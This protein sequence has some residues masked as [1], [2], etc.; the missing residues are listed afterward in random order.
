MQKDIESKIKD[1]ETRAAF[2]ASQQN[3]DSFQK[4]L[5]GSTL[6]GPE[7]FDGEHR[8]DYVKSF[9]HLA[10]ISRPTLLSLNIEGNLNVTFSNLMHSGSRLE[11]VQEEDPTANAA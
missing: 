5:S 2:K 6:M 7:Q 8:L 3:Y 4:I 11:G 1:E 9:A 10:P